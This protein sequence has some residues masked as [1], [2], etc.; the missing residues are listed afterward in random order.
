MLEVSLPF[1]RQR[2]CAMPL[3]SE[4]LTKESLEHGKAPSWKDLP[5]SIGNW[6]LCGVNRVELLGKRPELAERPHIRPFDGLLPAATWRPTCAFTESFGWSPHGGVGHVAIQISARSHQHC[7]PPKQAATSFCAAVRLGGAFALDALV[8]SF[9][10]L[11]PR[12]P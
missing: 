8:S 5:E 11:T 3:E 4:L 6:N 7:R 2:T 10:I 9:A 1:Y 12:P